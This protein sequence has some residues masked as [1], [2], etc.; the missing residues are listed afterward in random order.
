M[1]CLTA[2]SEIL[3]SVRD[4]ISKAASPSLDR[5]P[6]PEEAEKSTSIPVFRIAFD[7][8]TSNRGTGQ[9]DTPGKQLSVFRLMP[10]EVLQN[11][12]GGTDKGRVGFLTTEYY[13]FARQRLRSHP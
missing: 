1:A 10:D 4:F 2:A 5:L 11:I 9:A 8:H 7:P 6:P 12:K 13:E 3:T